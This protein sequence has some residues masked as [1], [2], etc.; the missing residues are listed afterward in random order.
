MIRTLISISSLLIGYAFFL[1]GNAMLTTLLSLRAQIENFHL[2]QIGIINATYFLGL[3]AGAKFTDRLVSRVG[4]GRAYAIFASIG[5][6]CALLHAL[7]LNPYMWMVIRLGTGFC[8]AGLF[9]VTESWLNSRATRTTRGQILSMYMITHYLA[10]G[11]G[12][13]FIP[14][15]DPEGLKLFVIAAIGFSLSLIPVL[16]TRLI[17]PPIPSRQKFNI[18]EIYS[19]SPVAMTGAL[20]CGLIGSALYGLAPVYTK[21]IG[22]SYETTAHFMALVIFSGVLLQWPIGRLSDRID[23]RKLMAISCFISGLLAI[24]VLVSA[25]AHILIFLTA[26]ALFGAFSFTVY[27]LALAHMND[28]TPEGKLLYAAGGMLTAFSVGAIVSPIIATTAMELIGYNALFMYFALI[29]V[30][31][32]LVVF[33][34]MKVSPAPERK[35]FRRFFR[36]KGSNNN[37]GKV[38]D[39]MDRDIAR[40][41][42]NRH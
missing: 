17:A 30:M 12:Q 18:R 42:S 15:A 3:Y 40:V 36:P 4:H 10:A 37:L 20:C 41:A 16:V 25:Q 6:I 29:F 19:Y 31:Y 23:R 5:S 24:A 38:R 1:S 26:A 7:L 34:R 9:M 35:K 21:G 32:A 11:I 14:F 33:W 8:I 39:A 22:M 2:I 28:A 27:P 13:L